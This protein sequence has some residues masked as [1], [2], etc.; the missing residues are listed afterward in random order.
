MAYCLMMKKK[1]Y[2]EIS[3]FEKLRIRLDFCATPHPPGAPFEEYLR[4]IGYEP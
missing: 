4:K 2:S 3:W 1:K